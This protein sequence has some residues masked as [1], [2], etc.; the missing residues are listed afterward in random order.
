M[1]REWQTLWY[2]YRTTG[3]SMGTVVWSFVNR[4][5]GSAKLIPVIAYGMQSS[6]CYGSVISVI[7][8]AADS[9]I[10]IT[11]ICMMCHVQRLDQ[12]HTQCLRKIANKCQ[13]HEQHQIPIY[14]TQNVWHWWNISIS[15]DSRLNITCTYLG[16]TWKLRGSLTHYIKL[17]V[18]CYRH[19]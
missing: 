14:R 15:A 17:Q 13:E 18:W 3:V 5:L 9:A 4:A 7:K 6:S 2:W 8:V 19:N 16:Y 12:F 10:I 1:L 11:V